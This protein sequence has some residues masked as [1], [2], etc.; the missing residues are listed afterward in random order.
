MD[1]MPGG[2]SPLPQT[3]TDE[4][5]FIRCSVRAGFCTSDLDYDFNE[6]RNEADQRLFNM[7]LV[8]PCRVLEQ[9]LPPAL[10]Q[11]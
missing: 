4:K 6:L 8:S 10:P 1:Q 9:L 3:V 2:V 7:I 5:G 11:S